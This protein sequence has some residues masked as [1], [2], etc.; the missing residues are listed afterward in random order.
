MGGVILGT[1]G[2]ISLRPIA[3]ARAAQEEDPIRRLGGPH[4]GFS[5][6]RPWSPWRRPRP[7]QPWPAIAT[8]PALAAVAI[9]QCRL[10]SGVT[11]TEC[12]RRDP[13]PVSARTL[14]AR[15]RHRRRRS[16]CLLGDHW[17]DQSAANCLGACSAGGGSN[18]K[19]WGPA[20]GLL[21]KTSVESV[22]AAKANSTVAC[23]CNPTC[24]GCGCH[25]AVPT[26]QWCNIN[27]V[28]TACPSSGLCQDAAGTPTP[29]PTSGLLPK[30]S[31]ESV[32]AAKANST[33]ACDCNPTCP[34]C[35]CH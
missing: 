6:R 3:W 31:V 9:M 8:P 35:G 22:E 27:G 34:G 21:Q 24:P 1:T 2:A 33:V 10:N 5:R 25:Y 29:P 19:T 26:Q 23:D 17:C 20:P 14:P 15:R 18:Q 12:R 28:Q 13:L 16:A 4:P 11:S 30:T 7:T 32:E